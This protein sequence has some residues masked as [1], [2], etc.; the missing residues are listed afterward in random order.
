MVAMSVLAGAASRVV[1]GGLMDRYEAKRVGPVAASLI[2]AELPPSTPTVAVEN[3][4]RPN[5]ASYHTTL[6]TLADVLKAERPSGPTLVLIGKVVALS[7][8]VEEVE[9]LAA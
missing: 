3:A 8:P 5:Q 6:A 4:S 2:A 1:L 9:R 7:R